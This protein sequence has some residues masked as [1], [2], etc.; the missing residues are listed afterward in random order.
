[1]AGI[2]LENVS[3]DYGLAGRR[4]QAVR[5][6]SLDCGDGE[7]MIFLGPSGCGKTST[8][9]MIAG[10]EDVTSGDIF[11][12]ERRVN[13]LAPRHRNVAMAFE[14]YA[15]YP[16]LTAS[17][18]IEFP[19]RA[20]G[21]DRERINSRLAEVSRLLGIEDLLAC[22]PSQLGGGHQQLV[23]LARCLIREADVYLLDEPLSHLDAARRLE[24]RE[25]IRELHR[26]AGQTFIYVTHDQV[27][28]LALA[29]R[30]A[31]MN[32]GVIQQLDSP[33]NIYAHPLNVF[34]A[35]FLGEPPMNI[36]PGTIV[37]EGSRLVFHAGD[38][39]FSLPVPKDI[40]RPGQTIEGEARVSLGIRPEDIAFGGNASLS[41]ISGTVKVYESLGEDGVLEIGCGENELVA[42]VAANLPFREGENIQVGI[43]T[44]QLHV[45]DAHSQ[46][47]L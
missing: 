5:C 25:K 41:Q 38:T 6:L 43:N 15:L 32:E 4:V 18:N 47:R 2:R 13:S 9:R 28:A 34:V 20:R 36:L 39:S 23:S 44:L 19:L 29:D 16:H 31:V 42:L 26:Q 33:E 21:Y 7:M 46:Q 45:F 14:N 37:N 11:I 10:L 40:L 3:K 8:M 17:Q 30:I 35:A 22:R 1:V 24:I 12:G 27:E